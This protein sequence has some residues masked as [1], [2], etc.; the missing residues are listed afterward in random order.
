MA[1]EQQ[2]SNQP[3]LPTEP[4]LRNEEKKL[5]TSFIQFL[6]QKVSANECTEQQIEGLEGRYC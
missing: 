2:S 3:P 4:V 6:R 1:S 5:V